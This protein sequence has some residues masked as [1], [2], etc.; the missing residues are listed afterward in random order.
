[1]KFEA[2]HTCTGLSPC[3]NSYAM[4]SLITLETSDLHHLPSELSLLSVL[5]DT[6]QL[7]QSELSTPRTRFSSN[8]RISNY[9]SLQCPTLPS[10]TVPLNYIHQ[11]CHLAVH[12]YHSSPPFA[13]D[14]LNQLHKLKEYLQLSH[15]NGLWLPF[16]GALLW[17]VLVGAECASGHGILYSWFIAQLMLLWVPLSVHRWEGLQ[18]ALEW[19]GRL[20][21]MR[22]RGEEIREGLLDEML[23]VSGI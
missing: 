17:C 11:S 16:P 13:D 8:T 9:L 20:L 1:M 18:M 22:R 5:K 3:F 23:T 21:K 15:M 4:H 10:M 19:F 12:L 14:Q 6:F 2:S 7:A